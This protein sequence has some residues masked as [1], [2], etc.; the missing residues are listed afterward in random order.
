MGLSQKFDAHEIAVRYAAEKRL[1]GAIARE[2]ERQWAIAAEAINVG[3]IWNEAAFAGQ[4]RNSMDHVLA[5]IVTEHALRLAVEIGIDFDVAVINAAAWQWAQRFSY[6]WIQD[7][8]DTTRLIVQ[9][10]V[11]KFVSTR[12]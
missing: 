3:R 8:T 10:A 2:F 9:N 5:G 6:H 11:A 7:I 4:V 12:G 1:K